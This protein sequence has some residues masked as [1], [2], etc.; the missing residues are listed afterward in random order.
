MAD[1]HRTAQR[2]LSSPPGR[3][4]S[5]TG[6]PG[7]GSSQVTLEKVLG[8]T[9]T[10]SSALTC[11]PGSG[12]I[13]YPAG[14]VIILLC[15]RKNKQSH[16]FNTTSKHLSA[17]AFSPD[18]TLLVSGESGRNP[19]VRVWDVTEKVQISEMLGHKYGVSCVCFSPNMKYVVS[20]GYQHDMV[21]NVWDWKNNNIVAKNKVSSKVNALSFSED[22]GYFVTAGHRH[23]KFWYLESS[24]QSQVNGTVPLV[25]RSGLLGELYNNVFGGVACGR[26]K[27]AGRTYCV[28]YS[29]LLC[30]LNEKRVLEKWLK[31]KVSSSSCLCV[32]EEFV[33]CGCE[34]G[35]VRMFNA[36]NLQYMADLPK[37]H[38]LGVD[39][40]PSLNAHELLTE[41]NSCYPDTCALV[42]DGGNH[43]LCCVYNDH[44]IYVWDL[45]SPRKVYS[46]LYHSSYIWNIEVSTDSGQTPCLP[47]GSFFTSSSDNT[48]R[49]WNS[50]LGMKRNIYSNDL[51]KVIYV[52]DNVRYLKNTLD[53]TE[54]D[55]KTGVRVLKIRHDGHQLASGDRTGNIRI[56]DLQSFEELFAIEA[57][58]D[59]VLCLDYSRPWSGGT[60]LASASRDRLIH[61]LDVE[62]DYSLLQTLD[63][64]SS[65]VTAVKFAGDDEEMHMISCGADRSVYFHP[66]QM[67]SDG[68]SFVRLH[69]VVEKNTLY[70][71]DI[72]V[73]QKMVAVACQDRTVRLYNISSGKQEKALKFPPSGGA[74]LKVQMDPSG[75]F[76]A[77]SCSNKNI[78][79][80]DLQTGECVAVIHGH[81]DPAVLQTNG[82]LPLWARK[83]LYQDKDKSDPQFFH[84]PYRY[85]PQGRW[86]ESDSA[87]VIV[88]F[89]HD[90]SC[91]STPNKQHGSFSGEDCDRSVESEDGNYFPE[92]I[93]I[94]EASSEDTDLLSQFSE[95]SGI[96]LQ[97][98]SDFPTEEPTFHEG[99]DMCTLSSGSDPDE[100][101]LILN[102]DAENGTSETPE[103]KFLLKHFDAVA[104]ERFDNTL[105]DLKPDEDDEVVN[106]RQS[107]STKFFSRS[108]RIDRAG[109]DFII[110]G[111]QRVRGI[112]TEPERSEGQLPD[113]MQSE[114]ALDTTERRNSDCSAEIS[115]SAS[116]LQKPQLNDKSSRSS[117]PGGW[118]NKNKSNKLK[119]YMEATAS[120][121]AKMYRSASMGDINAAEEHRRSLHMARGRSSA[122]LCFL[123]QNKAVPAENYS[124]KPLQPSASCEHN[125]SDPLSDKLLMPPPSTYGIVPRLKKKAKSISNL[126]KT[127][128][129]EEVIGAKL[130]GGDFPKRKSSSSTSRPPDVQDLPRRASV[131]ACPDVAGA[132]IHAGS[133]I[134]EDVLTSSCNPSSSQVTSCSGAGEPN[135][136]VLLSRCEHIIEELH[137]AFQ[138][139]LQTYKEMESC[140]TPEQKSCLRSLFDDAFDKISSEIDLVRVGRGNSRSATTPTLRLLEHY[141]EMM[142]QLLREKRD[143]K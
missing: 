131:V 32:T 33:F 105:S 34:E 2:P 86:A 104:E 46:A 41:S 140:A 3:R 11:D 38:S 24:K 90:I 80:S 110:G 19:A 30:Q 6:I 76:C 95:S 141:S 13:A 132:D 106:P 116:S 124:D 63:D 51:Y 72:D 137:D 70:D 127:S 31:L 61:I 92:R 8:M 27:N 135:A 114:E 26:G 4:T 129:K 81:S 117:Y 10:R 142:L 119:S 12:R 123:E 100:D 45:R 50:D 66:A 71:L 93:V 87:A 59:E 49:L 20:V 21:V 130:K 54:K 133:G 139:T 98:E 85:R 56:Y 16:I 118:P 17:L 52:N 107:L 69:H 89:S 60:L 47:H 57:H 74:L 134:M 136:D 7:K 109:H 15:P 103:E 113:K 18:G 122:S 35:V 99:S 37:P 82:R 143:D 42:Y 22:S 91:C 94:T 108:Q 23:L 102:D 62:H 65:S 121:K 9:V 128:R 29:G 138:K 43:W 115:K 1:K 55:F 96:C 73:T 25:G 67:L 84:S 58:D 78:F 126:S 28:S 48:I 77:T 125:S 97:E 53:T 83:L 64:H 36:H 44:S 40:A 88:K 120:F 101:L 111:P 14:C 75:G 112:D 5:S 68:I 39:V 79:I